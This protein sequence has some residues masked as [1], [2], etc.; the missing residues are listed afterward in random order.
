MKSADKF[1]A[2]ECVNGKCASAET[3]CADEERLLTSQ[4][5]VKDIC[6]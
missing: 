1:L 5:V 2:A 4:G 3:A 6:P